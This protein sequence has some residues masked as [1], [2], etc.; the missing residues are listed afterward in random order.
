MCNSQSVATYLGS[1]KTVHTY[2]PYSAAVP[3][4]GLEH[5]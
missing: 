1:N 3:E 4:S 5:T 2:N